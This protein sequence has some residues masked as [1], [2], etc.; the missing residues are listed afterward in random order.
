[1][2]YRP[3]RPNSPQPPNRRPPTRR[4]KKKSNRNLL[5]ALVVGVIGVVIIAL[6]IMG[7]KSLFEGSDKVST[8]SE[9]SSVLDA[10]PVPALTP[11]P[12]PT[13]SPT[14]EPA[15]E[16]DITGKTVEKLDEMVIVGDGAY[17]YYKYNNDVATNYISAINSAGSSAA[18]ISDV[19]EMIIPTSIDIML[20]L[21]FLNDYADVTSDQQKAS[22]Y[23]LSSLDS[24][25]KTVS[26][27]DALKAHCDE[28]LYFRTDNH[29]SGLG[30]YYMYEQW[31]YAKGVTPISLSDCTK[32]DYDGFLGNIYTS[33]LSS[34]ISESET[35]SV[36]EPKASLSMQ[37]MIEDGS[38]TDGSVFPDVANYDTSYKYSAFLDGT[39]IYSVINNSS[40]TDG[41]AA[42]LVIDSNGTAIAPFIACHYQTLYVI[43][44]R[45]YSASAASLAQEKG[46]SDI[47]Y[48]T[49]IT[50][51]IAQSL[52][53]SLENVN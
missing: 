24:S 50:A 35:V 46:A 8:G 20:P 29:I 39:H 53:D 2:D 48:C 41:S 3:N 14:P 19:Y 16:A 49:S 33:T 37:Y 9:S 32:K 51:T 25:V 1:M 44:Y 5:P 27:Y 15:K 28:N 31:A 7:I 26:V 43:D 22:A 17:E 11:T 34:A 23:I 21:D 10:T 4:K 6:V 45:S 38:L 18:G 40:I 12:E 13:A 47:I 52:V 30:A 36:Y 42:V